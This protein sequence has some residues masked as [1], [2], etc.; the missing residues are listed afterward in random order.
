[1]QKMQ[2]CQKCGNIKDLKVTKYNNRVGDS[3]NQNNQHTIIENIIDKITNI[4]NST[5]A[6]FVEVLTYF[7]NFFLLGS[8]SLPSILVKSNLLL[9]IFTTYID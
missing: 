5:N 9:A 7:F 2:V 8:N 4:I 3:K 6:V 1:M